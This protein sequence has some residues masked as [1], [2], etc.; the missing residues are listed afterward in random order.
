MATGGLVDLRT[1]SKV[2]NFDGDVAHWQEWSFKTRAW[3]SLLPAPGGG[4]GANPTSAAE[5]CDLALLAPATNIPIRLSSLTP[6]ALELSKC[7]YNVLVQV[8]KGRALNI[9]RDCER[10]N[11]LE[12]WRRLHAEYQPDSSL[13]YSAMLS[14]ILSPNWEQVTTANF[15]DTLQGWEVMVRDYQTQSHDNVSDA[16]KVAVILRWAPVHIRT[17]LRSHT[18]TIGTDF[19]VLKNILA[20]YITSGQ[21]FDALGTRRTGNADFGGPTPMDVGSCTYCGKTGHEENVCWL[22]KGGKGKG[23]GFGKGFGKGKGKGFGKD[24]KGK[25]KGYGDSSS[26]SSSS[27]GKGKGK[28][29]GDHY[30]KP[31]NG[32]GAPFQGYCGYCDGW[33]HKRAECRKR[34]RDLAAR[35]GKAAAVANATAEELAAAAAAPPKTGTVGAVAFCESVASSHYDDAYSWQH[36]GPGRFACRC[37]YYGQEDE[38]ENEREW[39]ALRNYEKHHGMWEGTALLSQLQS[40]SGGVDGWARMDEAETTSS[41]LGSVGY[42]MMISDSLGEDSVRGAERILL[43]SG[44]DEHMCPLSWH[45]EADTLRSTNQGILRDVQGNV[46][47]N[48]GQ[49]WVA[50]DHEA[51]HADDDWTKE[52]FRMTSCFT[53]GDVAEPLLSA[54]KVVA[55]G[56]TVHLEGGNSYIEVDGK[57]VEVTMVGRRF[58]VKPEKTTSVDMEKAGKMNEIEVTERIA[59]EWEQQRKQFVFG[60]EQIALGFRNERL[61]AAADEIV[62]EELLQQLA[63]ETRRMQRTS[64]EA[65]RTE[66]ARPSS[67]VPHSGTP[68]IRP[69][70]IPEEE[71]VPAS[72]EVQDFEEEDLAPLDRLD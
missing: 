60:A 2:Q 53:V 36:E 64:G 58:F 20:T 68:V 37:D 19:T 30:T 17:L 22:K 63:D 41:H 46:I 66:A 45:R 27:F 70:A 61:V 28:G 57:R 62:E 31:F 14:G 21:E 50:Q 38:N 5:F 7:M 71:M 18:M 29:K 51:W 48:R 33:G 56:G 15:L 23:K 43:D 12:C 40:S 16:I 54:G 6:E 59:R 25:G 3:F 34:E 39:R 72:P 1:F 10:D 55:A 44:S 4:V 47:P 26:S 9:V 32:K 42:V 24:G 49:R 67:W 52:Q 65:Q 35:D 11:G 69:A 8:C 13:R